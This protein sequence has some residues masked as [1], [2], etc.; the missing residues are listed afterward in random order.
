MEAVAVESTQVVADISG[1]TGV[2][3]RYKQFCNNLFVENKHADF[4]FFN[5]DA[6][7]GKY[8]D[9]DWMFRSGGGTYVSC[10]V[11]HLKSVD[12]LIII[13]DGQVLPD[14]VRN[15]REAMERRQ[16]MFSKVIVHFINTGGYMDLTVAL[17]FTSNVEQYEIYVDEV[18]INSGTTKSIDLSV[19]M[20]N[21]SGFLQDADKVIS[22]LLLKNAGRS[23]P[24]LRHELTTLQA[25]LMKTVRQ[26]NHNSGDVDLLTRIRH[27]S[28]EEAMDIMR[29]IFLANDP[30]IPRQV[31]AIFQQL[32]RIADGTAGFSFSSLK[33]QRLERSSAESAPLN[34]PADVGG[35]GAELATGAFECPISL[36]YDHPVILVSLKTYGG[37]LSEKSKDYLN[38]LLTD[39]LFL[40]RDQEACRA[41]LDS[42][43]SVLGL[44]AY[45]TMSRDTG[46]FDSP[47]TRETVTCVISFANNASHIKATKYALARLLFGNKIPGNMDLWFIVLYQLILRK[48]CLKD[49]VPSCELFLKER[50][51]STKT[52]I[53]LSGLAIQPMMQA[54]TDIAIWYCLHSFLF[55]EKDNDVMNRLRGFGA[56]AVYLLDVA[57]LLDLPLLSD[58]ITERM[59]LYKAFSWMMNEAKKITADKNDWK[60]LIRA[61]Y[62]NSIIISGKRV[63]LDGSPVQIPALPT[64]FEGLSLSDI[65]AL[66]KLV[67]SNMTVGTVLIPKVLD[68]LSLL[69]VKNYSYD[70]VSNDAFAGHVHPVTF[71]LESY[72][73]H[74]H[75]SVHD[76]KN[77]GDDPNK[78]M[79]YYNYFIKYVKE[80]GKYPSKDE[81]ILFLQS[82]Q[83]NRFVCPLDTLPE[84]VMEHVDD[85]FKEYT[86]VLH[87]FTVPVSTFIERTDASSNHRDR[88]RI[89]IDNNKK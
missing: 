63:F 8:A 70:E 89:E 85:L 13:T 17:P 51:R 24:K 18:L 28:A 82:K 48:E 39:P 65:V 58:K 1:S 78:R 88:I 60:D 15:A 87:N 68:T 66:S 14:D 19:Y 16:L 27:S 10:I 26:N 21:V 79:S 2:S 81:F 56:S 35:G 55:V 22:Q 20:D 5:T 37:I 77:F 67:N 50:L 46:E 36:D 25:N 73:N 74:L 38:E 80:N 86:K 11:P 83:A 44:D 40:L 47:F 75:W 49:A 52:A 57:R 43:D 45:R 61:Q 9:V 59:R 84:F 42:F 34:L 12:K 29:G 33:C 72:Y 6:R 54:P 53:T 32:F 69:P 7:S 62:Q 31:E 4:T 30:T 41:I 76:K 3:V 23:N 64:E 71:R